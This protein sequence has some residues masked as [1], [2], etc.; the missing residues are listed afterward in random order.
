VSRAAAE[1]L[2]RYRVVPGPPP[3][4]IY[5]GHE[6]VHRWVPRHS[7]A[8]AA[9]AG[10]GTI[11]VLGSPARHKNLAVL[12]AIAPE[13][14]RHG[15]KLAVVGR[16]DPRVFAG[17]GHEAGRPLPGVVWLGGLADDEL[18]AL[19]GDCLCLAFPSLVEGFGLPPLEAMALGCPV[20]ASNASCLPEICADAALYAQPQDPQAWLAAL[21]RLQA[22]PDLGARLRI[23]GRR[24]AESF[25]WDSAA[26][27]WLEAMARV[28][29][30]GAIA[31]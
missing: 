21:L 30:H 10:P 8:T 17:G 15:L 14:A 26:V 19:L 6:H 13:L 3:R 22:D 18:A 7:P 27:Q 11:V 2:S 16:V 24:R 5:N 20:V 31:N 23:A 28:D 12:L 4:V 1:A 25:R 9:V 29:Q